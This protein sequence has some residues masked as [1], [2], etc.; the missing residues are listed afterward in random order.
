M[1]RKAQADFQLTA[2]G[3]PVFIE[4]KTPAS[5]PEAQIG[6]LFAGLCSGE[7]YTDH[8]GTTQSKGKEGEPRG[9]RGKPCRLLDQVSRTAW[10][11]VGM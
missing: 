5:L 4:I 10:A 3:S 9:S 2:P 11:G 1:T 7:L 6:Q 8:D